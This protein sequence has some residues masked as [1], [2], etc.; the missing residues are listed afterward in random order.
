MSA[1]V[2]ILKIAAFVALSSIPV[3]CAAM[4]GSRKAWVSLRTPEYPSPSLKSLGVMAVLGVI[5]FLN[6]G[7]FVYSLVRRKAVR[8]GEA[9]VALTDLALS[10]VCFTLLAGGLLR[11]KV[12]LNA[13][14][15]NH[16]LF[17]AYALA[18][19]VPYV[20][21]YFSYRKS[22]DVRLVAQTKD[23]SAVLGLLVV[24]GL[25]MAVSIVMAFALKSWTIAVI[26][27]LALMPVVC[28]LAFHNTR[29][30]LRGALLVEEAIGEPIAHYWAK[31]LTTTVLFV[32]LGAVPAA[33]LGAVLH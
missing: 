31:I 1:L 14:S 3:F 2:E 5:G 13:M 4:Y 12:S 8:T 11:S 16:S 33:L 6:S 15:G 30:F 32:I 27:V 22:A 18:S 19:L 20:W 9:G 29:L 7:L 10:S 26:A 17:F 28:R 25:W 24:F 21:F 23:M